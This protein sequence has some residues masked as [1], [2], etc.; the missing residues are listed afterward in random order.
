[1]QRGHK[2]G[3]SPN[4]Q[5]TSSSCERGAYR[6]FLFWYPNM[7][8]DAVWQWLLHISACCCC[9]FSCLKTWKNSFSLRFLRLHIRTKFLLLRQIKTCL[10]LLFFLAPFFLQYH[11]SI[12]RNEF[13]MKSWILASLLILH[14]AKSLSILNVVWLTFYDQKQNADILW[15]SIK[16][17]LRQNGTSNFQW[18]FKL[19]SKQT[20]WST[21]HFGGFCH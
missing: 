6:G 9:F 11:G 12:L 15:R 2:I 5:N 17:P 3:P 18:S 10:H 4:K 14:S 13:S 16:W 8:E 21:T 1:M 7:L 20:G 19:K